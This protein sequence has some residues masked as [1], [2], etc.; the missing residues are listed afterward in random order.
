MGGIPLG[1]VL[2][3]LLATGVHASSSVPEGW[4]THAPREEISPRFRYDPTG[5][6]DR[7]GS[8]VIAS[9]ERSG[10][11]GRWTRTFRVEG[12]RCYHFSALRRTS[13]PGASRAAGVARVAWRD[14]QGRPVKQDE[15]SFVS[16]H[17][18]EIPAAL[19]EFPAATGERDGWTELS[20]TY[21]APSAAARAIVE[22]EFRWASH[23]RVE[24]AEISLVEA[25]VPPRRATRLATVHFVPR[26]A[27]TPEERRR[28]FEPLI[29]QAA[30][31][32]ADLV[33][34]PE[35]L[36]YG[37][38]TTFVQAAEPIPGPSTA[39][40]GALAKKHDLYLVAGLVEREG[41]LIYN[42]AVL[43]GPAGEVAGKYRKVCLPKGEIE[44]GLTPGDDYP[45]FETRF[46]RVGMMICYDGF[47]PEVAAELARHGAEVI[48]WPVMGMNPLLA[49]ARACENNVYVV[50]STHTD[51]KENWMIS[52]VYGQD[53]RPLAQATAWGTIAVAEVDLGHPILWPGMGNLRD[54][55]PWHRV[56]ARRPPR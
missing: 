37:R 29:E 3:L 42:V 11:L 6:P 36:T 24:W 17:S 46:G 30:R 22:L 21:R 47:F 38:G 13:G 40:F 52:A 43:I 2:G 23:A 1:M 45:V 44:A 14:E 28:A 32:K 50:S 27:G 48:A 19:P 5:G 39:Y 35:V 53:G 15:P 54:E 18:G 7:R 33:V 25:P 10:L 41:P 26:D 12:G 9:D 20:G 49:A 31:Q 56:Y 51:I 16:Y 34:L 55:M 8:F 4:T